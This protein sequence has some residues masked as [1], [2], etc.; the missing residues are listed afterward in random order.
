MLLFYRV[1]IACSLLVFVASCSP[2]HFYTLKSY[3]LPS[4]AKELMADNDSLQITYALVYPVAEASM[5]SLLI[6]VYNKSEQPVFIDWSQSAVILGNTTLYPFDVTGVAQT[7]AGSQ[8]GNTRFIP[9][10]SSLQSIPIPIPVGTYSAEARRK[11]KKEIVQ[12]QLG[13]TAIHSFQ[14]TPEDSPIRFRSYLTFYS[15]KEPKAPTRMEHSF[16]ASEVVTSTDY[17]L[18]EHLSSKQKYT[19]DTNPKNKLRR[20]GM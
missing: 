13:T 19:F 20:T 6:N 2:Y 8:T 14:F 5:G 15:E 7:M 18:F 17:R 11:F 4:D 3:D 1:L 10:R 12:T 9:P 16:W